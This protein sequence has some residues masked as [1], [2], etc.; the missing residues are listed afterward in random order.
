MWCASACGSSN[1]C[2]HPC[3]S[4]AVRF[5][6]LWLTDWHRYVLERFQPQ[7]GLQRSCDNLRP[8]WAL[9]W[10]SIFLQGFHRLQVPFANGSQLSSFSSFG[11]LTRIKH[12]N[13]VCIPEARRTSKCK[14]KV[15]TCR[16]TCVMCCLPTLYAMKEVLVP[17]SWASSLDQHHL[18]HLLSA[19]LS[20]S[21]PSRLA[22]PSCGAIRTP[23]LLSSFRALA[24]LQ[25]KDQETWVPEWATLVGFVH[26][27]PCILATDFMV[28]SAPCWFEPEMRESAH[29]PVCSE[30][31]WELESAKTWCSSY[32]WIG[33]WDFQKGPFY[34]LFEFI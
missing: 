7:Q 8:P 6:W 1:I 29:C 20:S 17:S 15:S 13:A 5:A 11:C 21:S 33:V 3:F 24:L 25:M 19:C 31:K 28:C 2:L 32:F 26:Q 10:P 12:Q 4:P 14:K 18:S 30:E 23:S 34:L 22:T 9:S 16:Y 27:M